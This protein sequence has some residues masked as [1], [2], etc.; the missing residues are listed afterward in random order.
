M[1]PTVVIFKVEKRD[2]ATLLPIIQ[3][4]IKLG[5]IIYSDQW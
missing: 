4:K 1:L 2:K 5:T 3:N